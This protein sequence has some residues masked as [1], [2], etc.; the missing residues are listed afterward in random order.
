MS[1]DETWICVRTAGV[2]LQESQKWSVGGAEGFKTRARER[3][4]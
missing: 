4:L 2:E 3:A 1:R